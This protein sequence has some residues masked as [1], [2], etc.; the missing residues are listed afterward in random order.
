MFVLPKVLPSGFSYSVLLYLIPGLV[1]CTPW[2]L[3]LS[4]LLLKAARRVVPV[5]AQT[6]SE[7]PCDFDKPH[8]PEEIRINVNYYADETIEAYPWITDALR[9][10]YRCYTTVLEN[11]LGICGRCKDARPSSLDLL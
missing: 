3:N 8:I 4:S 11:H 9:S 5:S 1:P 2:S 10:E 6:F 7:R